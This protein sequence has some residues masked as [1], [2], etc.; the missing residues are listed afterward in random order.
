MVYKVHT[1]GGSNWRVVIPKMMPT[2]LRST[3]CLFA[4]V[5]PVTV[6][7]CSC[8][9]IP[10]A[11]G[12]I[13][14]GLR[15]SSDVFEARVIGANCNCIPSNDAQNTDISCVS[16]SLSGNGQFTSKIVTR[17]TC[18]ISTITPYGIQPCSSIVDTFTP[19]GE[20]DIKLW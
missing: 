9:S 5:F 1:C 3:L 17:A 18:D 8:S 11:V 12:S 20:V 4:F 6:M 2:R 14:Q 7:G 19:N 10:G 15:S 16:A 13:C